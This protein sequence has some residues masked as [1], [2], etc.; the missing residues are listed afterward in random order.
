MNISFPDK[1]MLLGLARKTIHDRIA[2][3]KQS[4]GPVKDL[5]P[6]A[7]IKCGVFVSLY[8]DGKLRGCIGTFSEDNPLSVNIKNMAL[9][10][11]S[12]DN[13]FSPIEADELDRLKIELSILSP[14][15]PISDKSEII[16]GKHG[17]YMEKDY[18]RGTLLPHVAIQQ[19]WSVDEFLGNCARYKAGLGW[20]GWK[21]AELYTYEAIVFNSDE[22]TT[23][24]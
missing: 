7:S 20:D 12:S 21:N 1:R 3:E 18:D 19:N 6:A 13:R 24:C 9:S 17:I 5:P 23:D 22:V 11:S 14:R 4:L 10:A 16:L 15:K 2:P 8:V